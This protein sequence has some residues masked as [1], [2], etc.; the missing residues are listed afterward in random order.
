MSKEI[1]DSIAKQ[2]IYNDKSNDIFIIEVPENSVFQVS[3]E[4][5]QRKVV[6]PMYP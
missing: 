3:S 6:I 2:N 1:Q 5:A 4:F